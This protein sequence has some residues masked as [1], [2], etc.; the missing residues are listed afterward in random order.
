MIF[1][2]QYARS[3]SAKII[4]LLIVCILQVS[5]VYAQVEKGITNNGAC[6][7][8]NS[9]AIIKITGT[10]TEANYTNRTSGAYHGRIDLDGVIKLQGSWVNEA[11]SGNV[12]INVDSDGEVIFNGTTAQG[13]AGSTSYFEKLTLDNSSGLSLL[14][15]PTVN[16]VLSLTNGNILLNAYNLVIGTTGSIT[17][18]FGSSRMIVTNSSGTLRKQFASLTNFTFP[19]GDNSGNYSPVE[20]LNLTAGTLLNAYIGAKVTNSKHPDNGS[21]SEYL[22]RYWTLT[23]YGITDPVYNAGF[24]YLDADIVGTETN[25]YSAQ[26]DG[27]TRS[28]FS[29]V[30]AASNLVNVSGLST[31][32]DYTGVDGTFPTV[33]ITSTAPDPTNTSPIPVTITFGEVVSGFVLGDITFTNGS[34]ALLST[35]DNK[36]FTLNVTP[37][38][39]G[40]VKLDIDAGKCTDLAGN[41]NTA[42]SQFAIVYNS[43]TGIDVSRN[44]EI[45]IYS[46]KGDVIVEIKNPENIQFQNGQ[47]EIYNVLGLCVVNKS[48]DNFT[49]YRIPLN[50]ASTVYI[51]KINIDGKT[52]VKKVFVNR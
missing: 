34:S 40:V 44:Y 14:S 38:I 20:N 22:N 41:N 32:Y 17:G 47:I 43:P 3:V 29:V 39:D 26:F 35:N 49:N 7:K 46:A 15:S 27:S 8:V 52:T 23:Q 30:T 4:F 1:N 36:T 48:M 5:F 10:A 21:V 45:L 2:Q 31:F 6:M 9:G 13:I 28:L 37:A 33:S 19:I 50:D 24:K 16:G 11:A 25:I 42:A 18:T 51:V 12:L